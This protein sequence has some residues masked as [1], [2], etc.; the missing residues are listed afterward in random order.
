[1]KTNRKESKETDFSKFTGEELADAFVFP[2]D[3]VLNAKEKK[4]EE[5]FWVARRNQFDNRTHRQKMY[6]RLLQLKFQLEDYI[7]SSQYLEAFNFG[8]F[9]NEYV[10]RQDKKDKDFAVEVDVKPAVLSQYINNHR[11]PTDEFII[12]LEL[13]S[14]G[15][16]PA[17]NW[18]KVIQ[19]DKE[20]E[21]MTNQKLRD[22]ESKHVK[23]RLGFAY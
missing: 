4:D 15:L 17:I 9:L 12:R 22:E 16:I 7:D 14:N 23:N 11:K 10:S 3:Q 19:K 8:F 1:M 5:D 18:F 20:H 21:I 2:A 13:H 6:S